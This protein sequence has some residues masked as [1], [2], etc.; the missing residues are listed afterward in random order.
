MSDA[1]LR[2]TQQLT[3]YASNEHAKLRERLKTVRARVVQLKVVFLSFYSAILISW[4]YY[5]FQDYLCIILKSF[6]IRAILITSF[7]I[8]NIHAIL[9]T[10]FYVANVHSRDFNY[11]NFYVALSYFK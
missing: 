10:S 5:S 6:N 1:V 7:Y 4:T 9:I 11:T 8:A 3:R 2:M